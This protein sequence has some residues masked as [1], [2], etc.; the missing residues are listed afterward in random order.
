MQDFDSTRRYAETHRHLA[1]RWCEIGVSLCQGGRCYNEDGVYV[2]VTSDWL[3]VCLVDGHGNDRAARWLLRNIP[4]HLNGL[5]RRLVQT[6]DN[7]ETLLEDFF[8]QRDQELRREAKRLKLDGGGSTCVLAL[9]A[10]NQRKPMT[11]Y[12]AWLGDSEAALLARVGTV[13]THTQRHDLSN[14]EERERI[15]KAAREA[16]GR[17][18]VLPG[19]STRVLCVP[20]LTQEPTRA[21]G[22]FDFKLDGRGPV[23]CRPSVRRVLSFEEESRQQRLILV[24]DGVTSSLPRAA[25][26]GRLTQLQRPARASRSLLAEAL[27]LAELKKKGGR[28]EPD[29]VS[30]VVVDFMRPP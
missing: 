27:R 21:F 5:A 20:G 14:P 4:L 3:A 12:L 13:R 6:P 10:E 19:K 1:G 11:T 16:R 26:W 8:E 30:V 24:S 28:D 15:D 25:D 23:L 17:W 18:Q 7:Y 22:D 9:V 29:N 2:A